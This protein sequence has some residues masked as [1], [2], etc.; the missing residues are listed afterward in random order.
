MGE[1]IDLSA[2]VGNL[3]PIFDAVKSNPGLLSGTLSLL[4]SGSENRSE[5]PPPPPRGHESDRRRLLRALSPYLSPERQKVLGTVLPLLEAWEN[6]APLL[7]NLRQTPGK[8]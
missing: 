2:L 7:G 4:N 5:P 8:E 1:G 6:V 3:A